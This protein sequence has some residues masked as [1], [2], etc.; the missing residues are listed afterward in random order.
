M[1][2]KEQLKEDRARLHQIYVEHDLVAFRTFLKDKSLSD[3]RVRPYVGASDETLNR[4]MHSMKSRLIYLGEAWQTSRN[5]LR[6]EQFWGKSDT[7][8]IPLCVSCKHFKE[9][10]QKNGTPCMMLGATPQD[11]ACP[12][13]SELP[14]NKAKHPQKRV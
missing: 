3:E 8:Q 1:V 7:S 11:I 4:L 12:G 5:F 2:G 10:P 14:K 6:S 9:A 13:H